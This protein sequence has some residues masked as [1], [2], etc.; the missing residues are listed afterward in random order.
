MTAN[1][2]NPLDL[3]DLSPPQTAL[4]ASLMVNTTVRA[5]ALEAGVPERS[6]YRW[7]RDPDFVRA[8][9]AQQRAAVEANRARLAEMV[10]DALETLHASLGD[11]EGRV[12]VQ[13]AGAILAHSRWLVEGDVV[14]RIEALEAGA[15]EVEH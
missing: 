1:G 12:R 15:K 10:G 2:V 8:L 4:V 13:A 9:R 6:A 3:A 5:A 11:R 7:L 14:E